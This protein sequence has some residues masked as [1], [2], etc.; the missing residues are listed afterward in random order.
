MQYAEIGIRF[1]IG[2]VFVVAAVG[3]VASERS[4]AAFTTS[5]RQLDLV[6]V[7]VARLAAVAVVTCECVVCL[8]LMVPQPRVAGIGLVGA[9]VLLIVFTAAIVGVVARGT[10]AVCR[11]FGGGST[12]PLGVRHIVR[13]VLLA[14]LALLAARATLLQE[15]G[16]VEPAGL[17]VAALAGLLVGGCVAALDEIVALF[18]PIDP[19]R[20]VHTAHPARRGT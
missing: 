14:G 2:T 9:A 7:A 3:K 15:T 17:V 16:P 8:L 18:R 20:P 19:G 1:L 5:L 12:A 13:N 6:P 10:Q 11:C 4:F